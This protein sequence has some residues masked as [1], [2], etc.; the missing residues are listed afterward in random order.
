MEIT[1]LLNKIGVKFYRYNDGEDYPEIIRICKVDEVKK[2]I[3]VLDSK[4]NKKKI[5]LEDIDKYRQLNP[6]GIISISIVK[7]GNISDVIV[8]LGRFNNNEH[9]GNLPYAVCRQLIY[10]VFSNLARKTEGVVYAGMSISQETCPANINFKDSLLCDKLIDNRSLSVYLDDT[11]D[12]ILRLI[13]TKKY[14]SILRNLYELSKSTD[15]G[16]FE[17]GTIGLGFCSSFRELLE[18]NNFMY[19]FRRAFKIIDVPHP[20]VEEDE[21]LSIQNVIY[22]ENELKFNIMETYLIKYTKEI[23]LRT[24]KRNYM[25]VSS[26]AENNKS[27]YIVAFDKSDGVYVPRQV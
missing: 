15:L 5:T 27:I 10:D 7:N 6:D 13:S 2:T 14:D 24:I 8:S 25:L 4:F 3:Q 1:A 19:D 18:K 17:P 22:L 16:T 26:S 9:D 20:I 21:A 23:D 12:D 11:L